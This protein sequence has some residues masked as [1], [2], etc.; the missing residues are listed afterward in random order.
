MDTRVK[1]AY[2][3]EYVA[4]RPFNKAANANQNTC[5]TAYGSPPEPVIGPAIAGPVGSGFDLSPQAGGK[6]TSDS[7]F[8]QPRHFVPA[9]PRELGF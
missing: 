6:R 9:P 5:D 2:D 7:N 4:A 8:K 3:T 1:P